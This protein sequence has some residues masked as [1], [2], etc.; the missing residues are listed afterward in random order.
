VA[1]IRR[2]RWTHEHRA[3]LAV[4]L[5]GM[6]INRFHRPDAWGPVLAAMAGMVRELAEDPGS[7]YLGSR[8]TFG[9]RGGQLVQYW[10]SSE[11]LIRYAED[12]DARHRPAWAAF[13]RRARRFPGAVGIWHETYEVARAESIY[14]DL[15]PTGLA[16]ATGACPVTGRL[17]RA[18]GR[19]AVGAPGG[20][21]TPPAG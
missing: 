16:A 8:M 2:G 10:R 14:V 11:D 3:D 1:Q 17:D 20:V 9:W 18:D 6:R 12:R 19:L 5:I 15:P 21:R 7:G 13:N 4:F